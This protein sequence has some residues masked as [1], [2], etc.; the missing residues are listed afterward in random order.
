M[1]NDWSGHETFGQTWSHCTT[2]PTGCQNSSF[3]FDLF[4]CRLNEIF[5]LVVQITL[6]TAFSISRYQVSHLGKHTS[7]NP[8]HFQS[9]S[10]SSRYHIINIRIAFESSPS[11]SIAA[12]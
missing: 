10:P 4:S 6:L 2:H 5:I 9:T 7:L 8:Q 11:F 12:Q 1:R 3:L